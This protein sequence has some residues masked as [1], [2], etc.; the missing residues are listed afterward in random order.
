MLRR[1]GTCPMKPCRVTSWVA[2]AALL[3]S[4]VPSASADI[5]EAEAALA[6]RDYA[7]AAAALQPLADA[8]D[9]Y[10]QWRLAELYLAGHGGSTKDGLTLLQQAAKAGEPEAQGRLGVL[11]AKGEG[12]T[13]DN[14]TAYKWLA[15]ASRGTL[16][17]RSRTLAQTN[18]EVVSLRMSATQRA[19]AEMA[20]R[21]VAAAAVALEPA[22]A[23]EPLPEP[24]PVA[25]ALP[26]PSITESY[27]IQLASVPNESDVPEEWA[28][29]KKRIGAP[30]ETLELH[31]E[32]ADLGAQGTY[33]RLQ[34]GPFASQAA[35]ADACNTVKAGGDDCLVVGP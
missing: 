14:V 32:A 15:L 23:P 5:A 8:D 27:R 31:V 24:E 13:Q 22:A 6:A 28:R 12:V 17:G 19:E 21:T 30:L 3:L 35:A 34:A 20:T 33:H 4:A 2:L 26:T 18:L 11:Y 16:P 29:L 9:S 1:F 25:A 10:A 7:R